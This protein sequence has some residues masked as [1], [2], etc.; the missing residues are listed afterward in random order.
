MIV[1]VSSLS[2]AR[3]FFRVGRCVNHKKLASTHL[4]C[5]FTLK[6]A[7]YSIRQC[8]ANRNTEVTSVQIVFALSSRSNAS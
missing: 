4:M 8:L 7:Y 6:A 5:T 2:R 1:A 3:E